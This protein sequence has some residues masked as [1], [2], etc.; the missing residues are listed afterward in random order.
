MLVQGMLISRKVFTR[1]GLF[2]GKTLASDFDF[3]IRMAFL[4]R[5]ICIY[6]QR[7]CASS[8]P[9]RAPF[10]QIFSLCLLVSPY[11]RLDAT[12]TRCLNIVTRYVGS[13]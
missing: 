4:R 6:I 8:K 13:L 3:L 7:Y 9:P 1:V 5:E 10:P 12:P 2:D 11:R